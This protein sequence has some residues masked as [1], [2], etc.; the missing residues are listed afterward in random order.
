MRRTALATA[1]ATAL[2]L[3]A[4][5]TVSLHALRCSTMTRTVPSTL[6][7]DSSEFLGP[8]REWGCAPRGAATTRPAT[9]AGSQG[10]RNE[11][12]ARTNASP[13]QTSPNEPITI[14]F[15]WTEMLGSS[16]DH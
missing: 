7:D 16:E 5:T 10:R 13:S 2:G 8:L 4:A 9:R 1:L 15:N 6:P 14:I 11:K 12:P 3:V